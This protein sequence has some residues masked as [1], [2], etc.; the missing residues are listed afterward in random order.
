MQPSHKKPQNART[1][2]NATTTENRGEAA[3]RAVREIETAHL[4]DIVV[5]LE[6]L[7]IGAGPLG[8]RVLFQSAGGSFEGPR[9]RGEVLPGGGD[10]ALFRP[11]GTMALDVRLT[12][13]T[14]DDALVHMTY[15]GRWTVPH[16]LRAAMADPA[17]RHRIDPDRYYFRTTP[18]FETGAEQYAWLNDVVSA[19]SGYL[20]DGGVAYRVSELV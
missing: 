13:R 15:Q 11:D 9:L 1:A 16:E 19:G 3:Q 10:W 20:V 18:L 12:L 17:E 7:D 14:H 6:R 5:D 4:F 8:H 2:P